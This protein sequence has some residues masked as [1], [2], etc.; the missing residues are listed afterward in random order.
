MIFAVISVDSKIPPVKIAYCV[1][2]PQSWFKTFHHCLSSDLLEALIK[3]S[4][5]YNV[6]HSKAHPPNVPPSG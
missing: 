6:Y 1:Q 4:C 5:L 2:R 3:R